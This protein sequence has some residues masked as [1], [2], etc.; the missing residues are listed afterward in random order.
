MKTS[1][2]GAAAV[3]TAFLSLYTRPAVSQPFG[4]EQGHNPKEYE[5]RSPQPYGIYE[6][7]VPKPHPYFDFYTVQSFPKNGI[8]TVTAHGP[9]ITGDPFG[10]RA[11]KEFSVLSEQI[12]A[13]YGKFTLT[14]TVNPAYNRPQDWAKTVVRE[15]R[16]YKGL[17]L[18]DTRKPFPDNV[19]S[20]ALYISGIPR[21][22]IVIS[23]RFEFNNFAACKA[24]R[25]AAKQNAF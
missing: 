22:Y 1:A 17:W 18:S 21:D 25:E 12:S 16:V 20:V 23:A 15:E 10:T 9:E 11:R 2:F 14:D 24:E 5:G 3:M 13:K 8:C 19:D 7:T 6:I 4:V